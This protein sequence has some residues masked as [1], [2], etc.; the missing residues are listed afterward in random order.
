MQ[1]KVQSSL[2]EY[3]KGRKKSKFQNK[4]GGMTQKIVL[5]EERKDVTQTQPRRWHTLCFGVDGLKNK[6]ND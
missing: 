1:N 4:G 5:E 2:H 6:M 3:W